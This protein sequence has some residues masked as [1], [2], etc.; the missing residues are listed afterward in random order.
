LLPPL[1]CEIIWARHVCGQDREI[2]MRRFFYF[3]L[4]LL[5]LGV[6]AAPLLG[7]RMGMTDA[8]NDAASGLSGVTADL[9]GNAVRRHPRLRQRP[10]TRDRRNPQ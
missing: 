2:D 8:G 6:L 9:D 1:F 7:I 5:I 4:I 10:R 3:I